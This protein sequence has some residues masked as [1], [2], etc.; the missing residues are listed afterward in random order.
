MIL[1]GIARNT[2]R[3]LWTDLE[4]A[5][6]WPHTLTHVVSLRQKYDSFLELSEPVPEEWWD[7]PHLVRRHIEKL[8]PS[9]K[10]SSVA[11]VNVSDIED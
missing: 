2:G 6:E 3:P 1:W 7:I 11:E 10:G 5:S 8:Y 4:Y 9:K